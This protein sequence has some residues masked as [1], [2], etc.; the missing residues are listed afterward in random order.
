[1]AARQQAHLRPTDPKSLMDRMVNSAS[2][3]A[4]WEN[5]GIGCFELELA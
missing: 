5:F 3:R 1:M 2:L 4:I